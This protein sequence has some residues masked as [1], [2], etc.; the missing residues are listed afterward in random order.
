[1]ENAKG[2]RQSIP[3][4]SVHSHRDARSHDP[5]PL[6]SEAPT[7]TLTDL[8]PDLFHP[9]SHTPAPPL[10]ARAGHLPYE[11]LSQSI[12]PEIYG[13]EDVKK[14]L[15]LLMVG[16]VT[17][18]QDDGMR[19]RGDINVLLMGD[20]GVAKSQLLKAVSKIAPRGEPGCWGGASPSPPS[21]WPLGPP[22]TDTPG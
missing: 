22:A 8:P 20:P 15:L 13:H 16:G 5:T 4:E 1:M 3:M 6:C 2:P 12:A 11:F 7:E 17:T 9:H 10:S 19:I 14:A 18:Q 21:V